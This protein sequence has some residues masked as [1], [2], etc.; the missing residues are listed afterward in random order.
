MQKVQHIIRL[1]YHNFMIFLSDDNEQK[2]DIKLF[3]HIT[4]ELDATT[5]FVKDLLAQ[6]SE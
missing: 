2:Q 4:Y 5:H 6:H 1:L 3:L